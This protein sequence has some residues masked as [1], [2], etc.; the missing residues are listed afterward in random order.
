M[1]PSGSAWS[2]WVDDACH[3]VAA[4]GRW[5]APRTFDARGHAGSLNQA[6]TQRSAPTVVSFASNDYL[7]LST[8][9]AVVDGAR[10][11]LER[12]G[13]GSGAS[14]LVTG[15]RPVHHELE[16]RRRLGAEVLAGLDVAR[17]DRDGLHEM[18]G[19]A[20]HIVAG[21]AAQEQPLAACHQG[22]VVGGLGPCIARDRHQ[23]GEDQ[24]RDLLC[25]R[26]H[27]E[28]LS[29]FRFVVPA[30]LF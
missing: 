16:D 30:V 4:A 29:R 21:R 3:Q 8:H 9:P 11:A 2:A 25:G 13:A 17:I 1:T 28:G 15:S 10:R 12:W 18:R 22:R 23:A 26:E 5:R 14:R 27:E 24:E 19:R 20:G 7:G 6:P